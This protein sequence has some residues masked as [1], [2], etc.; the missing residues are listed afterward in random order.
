MGVEIKVEIDFLVDGADDWEIDDD[1]AA[2]GVF[3]SDLKEGG[4]LWW[5]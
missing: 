1:V 4:H 5:I 3:D 2:A